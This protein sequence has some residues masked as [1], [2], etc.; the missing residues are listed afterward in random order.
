[1][2]ELTRLL[3]ELVSIPSVNPMGR[4]LSGPELLE[5]RLSAYL[6]SWF[7][8]RGLHVQ[9]QPVAP[10]R[11]NLLARYD[12]PDARRTVLFDVHQDTVPTDGM[13]IPPFEPR[14]EVGKLYGRGACDVKASMAA[15]LL[16]FERLCR[17]RPQGS[18]SVVLACTVDEEFTHLGSSKLAETQSGIDLAVV[19][20]P[21]QLNVVH[22]HKGATRW[23]IR[24]RGVACH[25]STPD[26][27]V[28]AI[29]RMAHVVAALAD[30]ARDL[31]RT[32]P[33]PI[34]GPPSL[35]VGRIEGG[36]SVNIVPD[37]CTIEI[38][39]RMIPGETPSGCIE[40]VRKFLVGRL[41]N[42]DGVEFDPPWVRMPALDTQ[43]GDWVG[44]LSEAVQGATGRAPELIGVP[45]GTD[46]G[47][48]GAAGIPGVVFGPG[49]I[50]QAH[51]RDEWV[52]LDQV[53][54]AAE[55]YYRIACA[56]G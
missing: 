4:A 10:G 15:M 18:A 53:H 20:E 6:E 8:D 5:T 23:K 47:P 32:P 34:L 52:E 43:L 30:L 45:F 31:S 12:A 51:T 14:V 46:A 17:E 28:N 49:D 13:T 37:A 21:T 38:D 42:L 7:R 19:A 29:Y 22:C 55:A 25:S 24:A 41:G 56:L 36:L 50:A 26:R 27:G 16:A 11:D 40:Q 44:P 39:R 2:D 1:M 9:R 48:L 3:S 33:H 54:Q 35:S